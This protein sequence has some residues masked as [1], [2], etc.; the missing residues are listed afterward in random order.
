MAAVALFGLSMFLSRS[1]AIEPDF[2]QLFLKTDKR[3][4]VFCT[5]KI[6]RET[7]SFM[8]WT[9][10]LDNW[11]WVALGTSVM[12]LIFTY[13]G[14]WVEIYSILMRQSCNI[15]EKNKL[16][17]IFIFAAI[18]FTYGYEGIVSSYLTVPP[19][20]KAY[21]SLRELNS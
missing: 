5:T 10:P 6:E 16:L 1:E 21:E 15:L 7:L 2:Q 3:Y 17:V 9:A 18:I 20:F 13:R 8:F 11:S 12:L 14:Q 4:F 19:P